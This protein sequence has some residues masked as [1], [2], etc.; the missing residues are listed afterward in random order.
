M[1]WKDGFQ[2]S[3]SDGTRL[4]IGGRAHFD[5][6]FYNADPAFQATL[7]TPLLDGSTFRRTR[8][9]ADGAFSEMFSFATEVDFASYADFRTFRPEPVPGVFFTEVW[10]AANDVPWLGTIKAGHQL[11]YLTFAT[12]VSSRFLPFLE[13]TAVYDAFGDDYVFSNGISA[14]QAWLD[15]RIVT[16]LGFFRTNTRNS[17][18]GAG[19][20]GRHAFSGRLSVVPQYEDDGRSWVAIGGS[21]SLRAMPLTN[22][23]TRFIARPSIRGG[24]ATQIPS[25]LE[26]GPIFGPNGIQMFSLDVHGVQGPWTMGIEFAG[27]RIG[28]AYTGGLP[29]PDGSLPEGVVPRGDVFFWGFSAEILRFLTPGD[30]RPMVRDM[31][32]YGR[33]RPQRPLNWGRHEGQSHFTGTGAW[34]AGVRFDYVDLTNSGIAGGILTGVTLGVNWHFNPNSKIMFNYLWMHR[35]KPAPQASGS[36]SGFGIRLAYD[37]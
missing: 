10:L 31:P 11:E 5:N 25:L 36:F 21:F 6:V 29:L 20:S 9:R 37:F 3:G 28:D 1:S 33:V 22:D 15:R 4:H 16:W 17:P 12:T 14:T 7:P 27:S 2:F 8:L 32:S 26:T 35:Q 23:S 18:S 19:D 13:R 30:Y 34:E 24:A